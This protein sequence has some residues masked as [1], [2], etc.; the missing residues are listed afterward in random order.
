MDPERTSL[1]PGASEPAPSAREETAEPTSPRI[2]LRIF[3]IAIGLR[4]ALE[5]LGLVATG[6]DSGLVGFWDRWDASH[7]L[8]IA[9]V[10]YRSVGEDRLFIVFLPGFPAAI[11]LVALVVPNLTASGLVVS[12]GASVGAGWYLYRLARL[13]ADHH[14]A[15]RAVLLLFLF[16]SGYFLAAPY[17]EALFL[18]GVVGSLYAARTRR[19]GWAGAAGALATVTRLT[20]VALLPALLWE[21]WRAYRR[22]AEPPQRIAPLGAAPLG[23]AVYL[24]ANLAVHGDAFAFLDIQRGHWHQRPLPP[25]R[26]IVDAVNG[27]LEGASGDFLFIFTGRIAAAVFAVALL[28]LGWRRLRVGD[29]VYAWG[30]VL[31][32]LSASWLISLPRYLLGIYPLF[33]VLARLTRARPAFWG[34]IGA[35]AAAQ[36]LLFWRYAQGM[37]TF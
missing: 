9:E 8:R 37:W 16:P 15:W 10:G 2:L 26:S 22:D 35:G 30:S 20:G 11:A 32:V 29:H 28:V 36:A 19:W 27:I 25:W 34:V 17:S 18:L 4:L 21:A 7:F 33:I 1:D 6:G 31:L 3:L 13:D 5:I 14:E 23:L 12:L 24:G